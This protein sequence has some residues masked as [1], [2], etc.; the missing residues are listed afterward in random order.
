MTRRI[1]DLAL[2]GEEYRS[3][4]CIVWCFDDRFDPASGDN[5]LLRAYIKQKGF[6]NV[7]VVKVAGG[8]KA[9]AGDGSADQDFILDQIR[10]SVRLH[11]TKRIA[12][13]LHEDCGAYGGSRAFPGPLEERRVHTADLRRAAE[14]IRKEF[15][16]LRLEL[17]MADLDGLCLLDS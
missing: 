14:L 12:L 7:D 11:G 5:S 6:R 10:I 13:M 8:A 4:A 9:L 1:I 16:G 15:P 2:T 3:D 17:L